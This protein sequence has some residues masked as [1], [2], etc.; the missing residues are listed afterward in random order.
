MGT[1][2]TMRPTPGR[3]IIVNGDPNAS[4]SWLSFFSFIWG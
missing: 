4:S 1:K 3:P 2:K